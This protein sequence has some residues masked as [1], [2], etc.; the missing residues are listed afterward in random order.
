M[1]LAVPSPRVAAGTLAAVAAVPSSGPSAA[2]PASLARPPASAGTS[3]P[4]AV[5]ANA[6]GG[7]AG[8]LPLALPLR[9]GAAVV[10]SRGRGLRLDP[11]PLAGLRFQAPAVGVEAPPPPRRPDRKRPGVAKEGDADPDC[12]RTA[13]LRLGLEPLRAN[14]R[15]PAPPSPP[16]V[17]A[18]SPGDVVKLSHSQLSMAPGVLGSDRD[19]LIVPGVGSLRC[20]GLAVPPSALP[21][22]GVPR[23]ALPALPERPRPADKGLAAACCWSDRLSNPQ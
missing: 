16:G 3:T 9:E 20:L 23:T 7:D 10:T 15:W 22:V 13:E 12:W 11:G 19:R 5:G 21:E 1:L 6:S 4:V 2:G 8:R 18:A 14:D 17:P